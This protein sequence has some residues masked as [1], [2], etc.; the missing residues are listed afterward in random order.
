MKLSGLIMLSSCLA[1]LSVAAPMLENQDKRAVSVDLGGS[2]LEIKR[3]AE[4]KRAVSVDLGGSGLEIKRAAEDKRAVSVDLGGSGLE[5]KRDA[6]DIDA[7][8]IPV[9]AS[10]AT[11]IVDKLPVNV[12]IDA[13]VLPGR[14]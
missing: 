8:D 4:D 9:V 1:T 14:V 3:A 10:L 12:D 5:I 6:L 13:P 7:K 11:D 2:G